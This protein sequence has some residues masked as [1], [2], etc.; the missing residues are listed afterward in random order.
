MN[1]AE[2]ALRKEI[3]ETCRAMN[4]SGINQG[5]SGNV[6]VRWGD[7]LLISP[8]SIDYDLMAPKDIVYLTMDGT[9]EGNLPPS[10]EWRFHRAILAERAEFNAV[11][12]AHPTYCTALAIAEREIPAVHYMV[13]ASGGANV[14]CSPY[15]TYGTQELSD[16]ALA[17]LKDRKCCL[18]AHHGMIACGPTL[19]KALWL[20]VEMETLARQYVISLQLGEPPLLSDAEI[21][22]VVAKFKEYGPKGDA[23]PRQAE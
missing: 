19:A 7:G 2:H 15:A 8:S 11:V 5:M 3:V 16:H 6:S 12:H 14:R 20:A 10:T 13:A 18:L 17:A 9:Y 4:R 23:A 21:A 22:I 1:D